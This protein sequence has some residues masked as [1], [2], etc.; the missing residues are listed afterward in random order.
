MRSALSSAGSGRTVFWIDRME[1][2]F[3]VFMGRPSPIARLRAARNLP[4]CGIRPH[5][6][7]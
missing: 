1:N 3:A 6:P 4:A 7:C 5:Q 2:L